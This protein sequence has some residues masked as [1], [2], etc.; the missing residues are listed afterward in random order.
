MTQNRSHKEIAMSEE[1]RESKVQESYRIVYREYGSRTYEVR[2]KDQ[3]E[4]DCCFP[5]E[6]EVIYDESEFHDSEHDETTRFL[7]GDENRERLDLHKM[8][9]NGETK[10]GEQ[11]YVNG[12]EVD[13]GEKFSITAEHHGAVFEDCTFH[14]VPFEGIDFNKIE[15]INCDFGGN[16]QYTDDCK[17]LEVKEVAKPGDLWFRQERQW[18][19]KEEKTVNKLVPVIIKRYVKTYFGTKVLKT[20]FEGVQEGR[21]VTWENNLQ[22]EA[23]L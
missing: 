18:D 21:P 2:A 12:A 19:Q 11:F 16:T 5:E 8:W 4:V 7:S 6:L 22:K 9:K 23:T 14:S 10:H 15:F 13:R 17:G 1:K 3:D 20:D